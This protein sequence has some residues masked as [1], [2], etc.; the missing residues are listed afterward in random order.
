MARIRR[1][2]SSSQQ[3]AWCTTSGVADTSMARAPH[4]IAS[5]GP[6]PH[7]SSR[8]NC[9]NPRMETFDWKYDNVG[10]LQGSLRALGA[11]QKAVDDQTKA[12]AEEKAPK[13]ETIDLWESAWSDAG[14]EAA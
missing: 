5:Q 11:T 13:P 1:S 6:T 7:A 10:T 2:P 9:L 4:T 12:D 14:K 8:K 3:T